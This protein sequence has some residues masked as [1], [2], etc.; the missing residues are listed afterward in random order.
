MKSR[1]P[2]PVTENSVPL[3]LAIGDRYQWQGG[4]P[5]ELFKKCQ[6][7][8]PNDFWANLSLGQALKGQKN[9]VESIRYFQAAV[10]IRP[11][12]VLAYNELGL[13]L[14][15]LRRFDDAI[16]MLQEAVRIDP[17]GSTTAAN[18]GMVL[19][20]GGRHAEAIPTLRP[21]HQPHTGHCDAPR[22][23]A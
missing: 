13:A 17:K 22:S 14:T 21:E 18:L 16:E 6:K 1:S 11:D 23:P 4:N 15:D 20:W 3:L 5:L 2:A 7:A 19:S 10:A 8:R 12:S 9:P